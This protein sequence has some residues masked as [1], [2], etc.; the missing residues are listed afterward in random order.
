VEVTHTEVVPAGDGIDEARRVELADALCDAGLGV[1]TE[2]REL[3]PAFVVY[4]PSDDGGVAFVLVDEDF[5]LSLEFSLGI[6]VWRT[7]HRGHVLDHEEAEFVAGLVEEVGLYFD[8]VETV[9][10][11]ELW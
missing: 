9:R 10:G 7:A 8:L 1:V 5:N 3:A 11:P 4:H 2:G 6:G